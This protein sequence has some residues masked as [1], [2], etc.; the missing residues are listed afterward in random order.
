MWG[1]R[2]PCRVLA[3]VYINTAFLESNLA[4]LGA[5][6]ICVTYDIT[7]PPLGVC[8][9]VCIYTHTHTHIAVITLST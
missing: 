6:I 9:Y 2:S 3:R 7:D 1:N 8:M 5:L 4:V